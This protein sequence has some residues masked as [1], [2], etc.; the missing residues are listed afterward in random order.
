MMRLDRATQSRQRPA[1]RRQD[2]Q[3]RVPFFTIV[4]TM[5]CTL[6]AY[7]GVNTDDIPWLLTLNWLIP[8][9]LFVTYGLASYLIV[10]RNI[11]A[12]WSP[13]PWFLLTSAIYYGFGPLVY[14]Y[15]NPQSV[16][17]S[18]QI[19][20]ILPINLLQTH[21]L[22]CVGSLT[23]LIVLSLV[24][25][26]FRTPPV[27]EVRRPDP[28]QLQQLLYLFLGVGLTTKYLFILPYTFGLTTSVLSGFIVSLTAFTTGATF[29]IVYMAAID[30]RY[31]TFAIIYCGVELVVGML[32]LAKID[33][34]FTVLM[35]F[36]GLYNATNRVQL[37]IIGGVV[38]VATY[39]VISPIVSAARQT[40]G[41]RTD[42]GLE[43]RYSMMEQQF[44]E[45]EEI[46]QTDSDIQYWWTRLNYANIQAFGMMSFDNG[47]P[48]SSLENSV[49][50]IIPR[51]LWPNKPVQTYGSDL[52]ELLL[53]SRSSNLG[54][55]ISGE[56][57]WNGGWIG[58]V[59][60]G[61]F[62]GLEFAVFTILG[63]KYMGT[64]DFRW[65]PCGLIG[66]RMGLRPDDWFVTVFAGPAIIAIVFYCLTFFTIPA[67]KV[68]VHG[69]RRA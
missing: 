28:L 23:I 1:G 24:M 61:A 68:A 50:S 16:A 14:E 47:R 17:Y 66:L 65:V 27:L 54:I 20:R 19:Y 43:S 2:N 13:V 49:Y 9:A 26:A 46:Y 45:G 58:V 37:L 59:L 6:A 48:G 21:L 8:I 4:V 18:D 39:V 34:L 30:R 63:A 15:G 56:A 44:A 42:K 22:N 33:V 12:I 51:W 52:N 11:S 29:L 69:R 57:Y 35:I 36:L 3:L 25:A 55:G 60:L 38:C 32:T 5:V 31:L 10:T 40:L 64:L 53:R 62:V 7:V 67:S 41:T